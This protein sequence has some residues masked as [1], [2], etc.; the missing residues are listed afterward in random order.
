MAFL[1]FIQPV[2]ANDYKQAH[3]RWLFNFHQDLK[4]A[5]CVLLCSLVDDKSSIPGCRTNPNFVIV[6]SATLRLLP[7]SSRW[8]TPRYRNCYERFTCPRPRLFGA[9]KCIFRGQVLSFLLLRTTLKCICVV[10]PTKVSVPLLNVM[11]TKYQLLLY[12]KLQ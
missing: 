10:N 12:S 7:W 6:T 5:K 4:V 3:S 9:D 1:K 2:N 8:Y 11:T